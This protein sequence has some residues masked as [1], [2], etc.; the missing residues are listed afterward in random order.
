MFDFL[1]TLLAFVVTLGLLIFVHEYGHFWVARRCG[2][3]VIRFS[4][5]F[6]QPLF[7]WMD[8]HG[9]EFVVATLPLGG[10]VKMLGEPGSD[11]HEHQKQYSFAH[12]SVFQRFAIVSAGPLVNLV[13]AIL[14][15][16]MLFVSG[17]TSLAPYVGDVKPGS[18]AE[19]AGFQTMDEIVAVDGEKTESWDDVTMA[20][21]AKIGESVQVRF[22]VRPEGSSG[23]VERTLDLQNWMQGQEKT[24]PLQLLGMEPFFPP[25][26]PV[27]GELVEGRAAQQQGMQSGDRVLAVNEVEIQ[28][29]EEWVELIRANPG[30]TM[31][32][33]VERAGNEVL[34]Q[35][36]PERVIGE[37][38][39]AFGQIGAANSP[40]YS[41]L[42]DFMVR[43][44]EYGPLAAV[45]KSITYAWSRIELTILSIAKMVTGKIS[46]DN[47]SGPIT[48]AKVA[49]DS[50]SYGIE[51]FLSFMAY[52]S[53]SLGVLNLL[54][55]PVLDGGHL[56]YYLV[57]MVK[58]S[59]VSEKAQ[60]LGNSLGLGLLVMFM[61]LAF[62]NDIMGL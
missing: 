61:G 9:T 11:I 15:Y 8:R 26:P 48:I 4:V 37:D 5:G 29:W 1:Q 2:V 47:L 21:I 54:P 46:L 51:P 57:E 31:S 34:L 36:T 55:I 35:I 6:G 33:L 50:A 10:F 39:E 58:G 27:L 18:Q 7:K 14:L 25:I 52:L 38:G 45:G 3:K 49:G 17:V 22:S 32:V 41:A 23:T 24:H 59:P 44:L 20:L 13:F 28:T 56:M 12:K 19:A 62:Y 42:P 16:W 60:A 43:K 53:I 40:E 30:V